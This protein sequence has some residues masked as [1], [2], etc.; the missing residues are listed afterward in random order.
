MMTDLTKPSTHRDQAYCDHIKQGPC[1]VSGR[2]GSDQETVDP[3]HFGSGGKGLKA[4]DFYQVGLIHSLHAEQ[5]GGEMSF[6][7]RRLTM[8]Y[9]L[10]REVLR[11][12][13]VV[14]YLKWKYDLTSDKG[15]VD[16][17]EKLANNEEADDDR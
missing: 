3:A 4:H 14:R 9:T 7:L 8:D 17:L 13:M 2:L 6:W 1:A 11:A 16:F 5:H 15:L 12:W 10:L